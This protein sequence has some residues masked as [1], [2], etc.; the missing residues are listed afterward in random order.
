[1]TESLS[2]RILSVVDLRRTYS[3]GPEEVIA[4]RDVNIEVNSG[5]FIAGVGRVMVSLRRSMH[6][7]DLLMAPGCRASSA[8]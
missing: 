7:L 1:M 8:G 6:G 2:Q 3:G 5:R 4:I